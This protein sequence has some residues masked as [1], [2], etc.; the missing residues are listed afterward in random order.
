MAEAIVNLVLGKLADAVVRETLFPNGAGSKLDSLQHELRWIRAFVK[1]TESKHN[2]DERVK[3]WVSDVR[4]VA[5][6]IE[7]AIDTFMAEVDDQNRPCIFNLV[8]RVLKKP[9]LLPINHKLICEMDEIQV[10]LREIKECTN[11]YGI[12]E[13]GDSS[14][15]PT[16]SPHKEFI[17]PDMDDPDVVG[18]ETDK[19]NIVDLLL[20][21]NMKRRCV[22]SIVGQGGLGKTTL[23]RKVY[24][25]LVHLFYLI[26]CMI[27]LAYIASLF[28]CCSS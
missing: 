2:C 21:P 16:R 22:L 25:R 11:K 9:R 8:M 27:L 24:N 19:E 12:K 14:K 15:V 26:T 5:Y 1:D 18:L 17:L 4:E 3:T 28:V 7:D 10:R 23:A 20:A 6:R 13:L